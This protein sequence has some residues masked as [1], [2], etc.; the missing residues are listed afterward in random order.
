MKTMSKLWIAIAAI[1]ILTPLGL[2]VP[3]FFKSYGAWGEWGPDE[4]NKMAGFVPEK[5]EKLSGIWKAPMRNY[6]FKGW[7]DK[8]ALHLSAA[9]IFSAI[10]G[11]IIIIGI[12]FAAGKLLAKKEKK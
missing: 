11:V 10:L 9:Y 2:F 8:G 5:L 6:T 12:T 7:E 1:I 3:S 4:I